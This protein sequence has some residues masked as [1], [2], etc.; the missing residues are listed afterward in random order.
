MN[1]RASSD[2]VYKASRQEAGKNETREKE[3]KKERSAIREIK[4]NS[5]CYIVQVRMETVG[6]VIMSRVPHKSKIP[7]R[8][9]VRL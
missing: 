9:P 8:A 7:P 5:E 1:G 4:A 2:F 6:M 3:E